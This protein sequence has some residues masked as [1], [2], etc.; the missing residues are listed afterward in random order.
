MDSVHN[1]DS[2][3]HLPSSQTYMEYCAIVSGLKLRERH[4]LRGTD[5][6][7]SYMT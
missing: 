2:Y 5:L 7:I 6:L 4:T 3:V 1:F